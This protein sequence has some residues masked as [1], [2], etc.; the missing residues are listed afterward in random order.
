MCLSFLM[1]VSFPR[2]GKFTAIMSS[3]TF[4]ASLSVSFS[5]GTSLMQM[6]LCLILSQR[7]LP[8]S[9][10][11]FFSFRFFCSDWVI[12]TTVFQLTDLS[13]CIISS[14]VDSFYCNLYLSYSIVNLCLVFI[15]S[16]SLLNFSLCSLS[17]DWLDIFMIINC[18]D[19]LM[20]ILHSLTL[21]SSFL[22]FCLG[23]S[24]GAYSSVFAHCRNLCF[25]LCVRSAGC[26][27]WL[28][29]P[30]RCRMGPSGASLCGRR[31]PVPSECPLQAAWH[32]LL[33]WHWQCVRCSGGCS[34][35]G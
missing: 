3:N 21:I 28:Y 10:L 14:A 33:W 7:S 20:G 30:R 9:S 23:P 2:L 17:P 13:L 25:P 32:L 27:F 1:S 19:F 34:Q 35:P 18:F 15:F 6:V 12:S 29:R 5:F 8:R 4:S 22:R 16:N 11:I 31:I 24:S 26:A